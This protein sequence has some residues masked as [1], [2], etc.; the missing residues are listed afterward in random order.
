MRAR[1]ESEAL[2]AAIQAAREAQALNQAL[3][4]VPFREA[5]RF[6]LKLGFVSFGGPTGQIALLHDEVVEKRRWLPEPQFLH[7]MSFCMLL[8]GP[9]AQQLATYIGWLLH[10]VRGGIAA[11]A[12]FVLPSVG[13]LLAL[14]WL[15]VEL[16]ELSS[17]AGIFYGLKP[18]VIAIVATA[19]IRLGRRSLKTNLQIALA[20]FAWLALHFFGIP[21]PW[22]IVLAICVGG[23]ISYLR[24]LEW[25]R[26][27]PDLSKPPY[28]PLAEILAHLR[29][30]LRII[31]KALVIWWTPVAVV[32]LWLG[33]DSVQVQESI[34]FSKAALVTF[35]GAYAVLPYVAQNAV[36]QF[37][38]LSPSEMLDGLGLAETT[39]GPLI[40][41]VQ[42]VGFLGGWH[43]PGT[44]SPGVSAT[45]GALLSTWVTFVPCFLWIFL[46]APY[47][48][49]IRSIPFFADALAAISATVVGVV[50]NLGLWFA[51]HTLWREPGG[52]DEYGFAIAAVAFAGLQWRGWNAIAVIGGSAAAGV[53]VRLFVGPW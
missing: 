3:P 1:P 18:A 37:A 50:L 49:K 26:E 8:P 16:G 53:A 27:L 17:V 7:A 36:E 38:W 5:L 32:A 15:Y 41:V 24:P 23:A 19:V 51:A 21:F 29:R 52:F 35:G 28:P 44:L 46:G 13:I 34:F 12:L 42:F 14:S 47:V 11:G 4:E 33:R 22:L 48:E 40:M 30:A 43:H 9:E 25:D 39:P 6:W 20:V 45:I 31:A 2:R 10:G